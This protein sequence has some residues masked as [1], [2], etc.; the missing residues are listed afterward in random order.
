ET[1]ALAEFNLT[2]ADIETIRRPDGERIR[3][4]PETTAFEQTTQPGI[5]TF[6]LQSP[7]SSDNNPPAFAVNLNP[8]ESRTARMTED[9]LS[10]AGVQLLTE[11]SVHRVD[12]AAQ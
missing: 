2:P 12:E 4:D 10:A 1:V 5:Y 9:T 7:R 11:E 8:D 3:L 6:V